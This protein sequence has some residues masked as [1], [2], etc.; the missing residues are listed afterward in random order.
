MKK[1]RF[2]VNKG[3][4]ELMVCQFLDIEGGG[5][6]FGS[7]PLIRKIWPISASVPPCVRE[8]VGFRCQK[9]RESARLSGSGSS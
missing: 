2:N 4:D 7:E 3:L 9:V 1:L 8:I 6:N 5:V